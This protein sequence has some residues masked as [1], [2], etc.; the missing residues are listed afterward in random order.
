MEFVKAVYSICS[1]LKEG[2]YL[3]SCPKLLQGKNITSLTVSV[4]YHILQPCLTKTWY[5]ILV[6]K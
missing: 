3:P 2:Q 6:R 1:L 5:V 4:F